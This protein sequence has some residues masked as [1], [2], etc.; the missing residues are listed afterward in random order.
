MKIKETL[1]KKTW[2]CMIMICAFCI[3]PMVGIS[4]AFASENRV[5]DEAGLLTGQEIEELET[6]L[7]SAKEK[8]HMDLAVL[9][10]NDA[11]GKTTEEYADDYYDEH[12][13]GTGNDRSGALCLIDM[14]NRQIYISTAGQMI[15]YLTDDR[16]SSIMD[17]AIGYMGDG[18]YAE[19]I[20]TMLSDIG[21]YVDQGIVSDQYNYDRDTGK[22]DAYHKRSLAWYEILIAMIASGAVAI[23][24]CLATIKKY[25]MQD[26]RKQ[27]LNYHLA[28]RGT[29]AFAFSLANDMFINKMVSQRR[30]GQN[31]NGRGPGG[32]GGS[33][34]GRSTT[35]QS[36]GGRTHGGGGRGF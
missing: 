34:V 33:S 31:I 30:I 17:D 36:S 14:D 2:L 29:S 8:I 6:N 18:S 27:A 24:P 26:E 1:L 13:L 22:V 19:A 20:D 3:L 5:F 28:Y 15:R 23:M 35:H 32:M 12:E 21:Q 10:I 11:M 4:S 7:S 25:K 9:T 16:I